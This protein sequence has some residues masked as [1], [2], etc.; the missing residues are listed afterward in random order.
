MSTDGLFHRVMATGG[1]AIFKFLAV[2]LICC[3]RRLLS[4]QLYLIFVEDS[5]QVCVTAFFLLAHCG[6]SIFVRAPNSQCQE[7]AG[8]ASQRSASNGGKTTHL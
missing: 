5:P 6:I 4:Q 7:Y 3:S 2:V 8:H 1:G